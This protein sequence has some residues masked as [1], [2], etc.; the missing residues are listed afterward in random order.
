MIRRT[1]EGRLDPGPRAR[2]RHPAACRDAADGELRHGPLTNRCRR[3]AAPRSA[4]GGYAGSSSQVF[5]D[6]TS[7]R[8]PYENRDEKAKQH[9]P[10]AFD[11][12][13]GLRLSGHGERQSRHVQVGR[14]ALLTLKNIAGFLR[15][16]KRCFGGNR[17]D[18]VLESQENCRT[19][20]ASRQVSPREGRWMCMVIMSFP[21]SVRVDNAGRIPDFAENGHL[22]VQQFPKPGSPCGRSATY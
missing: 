20:T 10:P 19:E 6:R 4:V 21:P 5:W 12:R 14:S 9:R 17:C 22:Q 8:P 11:R 16:P 15:E 3:S 13:D 2:N 7:V 18:Q 1:S